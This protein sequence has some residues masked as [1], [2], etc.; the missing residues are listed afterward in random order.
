[1]KEVEP[2]RDLRKVQ[3]MKNYLKGKSTRDYVMFVLGLNIALRISD[4][5]SLHWEDVIT[6][7]RKF[8]VIKLIEGK[9]KKK[10]TIMINKECEKALNQYMKELD[11][12]NK[13]LTGPLFKSRIGSKSITR[14]RA[15]DILKDAAE[16]VGVIE[17]INT[18]SLRKTWGYHAWKIGYSPAII[19][20]TLNHSNLKTTK[21]YLGITQEDVNDL[22][23]NHIL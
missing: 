19:M 22:Y 18:H 7:K 1:M 2:I 12:N 21:R 17:E 3:A 5:L 15:S 14:Q 16:A 11:S 10:R 4:L 23:E 13:P 6:N 8:K 20:E 9:T